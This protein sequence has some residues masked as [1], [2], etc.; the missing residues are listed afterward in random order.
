MILKELVF[1]VLLYLENLIL[2]VSKYDDI[3][4]LKIIYKN[5]PFRLIISC[6]GGFNYED[7][8]LRCYFLRGN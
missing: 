1:D 8:T 4:L 3:L 5:V 6:A 7:S 2:I